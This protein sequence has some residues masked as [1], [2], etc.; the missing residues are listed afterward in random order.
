[1]HKLAGGDRTKYA[2]YFNM[3]IIEF[4]NACSFEHEKG[5]AR[6]ERLNQAA[7][8]AKRAKDTN[9]YIVALL[10]EILD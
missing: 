10:Q 2:H 4:L 5:R 3:G 6:G 7:N 1:M 8:D 9:V